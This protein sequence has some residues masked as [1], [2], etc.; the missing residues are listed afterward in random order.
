M[1]GCP[2]GAERVKIPTSAYCEPGKCE[3]ILP[4]AQTR[5]CPHPRA[6]DRESRCVHPVE[7]DSHDTWKNLN[8]EG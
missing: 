2:F 8:A 4:E 6:C 1:S 7:A 5:H 3:W